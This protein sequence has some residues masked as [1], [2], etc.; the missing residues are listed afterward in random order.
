MDSFKDG[1]T[2]II[3][4]IHLF[5]EGLQVEL[6]GYESR[7]YWNIREVQDTDGTYE[8]IWKTFGGRGVKD[9]AKAVALIRLEPLHKTMDPLRSDKAYRL[10]TDMVNGKLKQREENEL[11]LILAECYT[12]LPEVYQTLEEPAKAQIEHAP[13]EIDPKPM[14]K[15]IRAMNR[16]FKK[17]ISSISSW[18]SVDESLPVLLLASMSLYPY[19]RGLSPKA[20]MKTADSLLLDTFYRAGLKNIQYDEKLSRVITHA[21]ALFGVADQYWDKDTLKAFSSIMSDEGAQNLAQCNEYQGIIWYNKE[22]MQRIILLT[23][24]AWS[25]PPAADKD[26][27]IDVYVQEMLDREI[28]SGYQLGKLLERTE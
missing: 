25:L 8:S 2:Y 1:L 5:D 20:A 4:S 17:K 11:I 28:R 24:L 12:K 22:E 10:I 14:V 13:S 3:P 18:A 9:I 23:A 7:V 6:N 26:F 19:T 27:E 16:L 15:L 21:A